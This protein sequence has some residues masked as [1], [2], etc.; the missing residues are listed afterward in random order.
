MSL[1]FVSVYGFFIHFSFCLSCFQSRS[2]FVKN[3]N[4][5]TSDEN[6]RK[7]FGEQIKEGRILS[8]KVII[9]TLQR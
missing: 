2:L 8:V 3:L 1:L 5:K 4:F 6:L 9:W 7:H